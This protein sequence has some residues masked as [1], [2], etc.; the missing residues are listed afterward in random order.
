MEKVCSK[1]LLSG[2]GTEKKKFKWEGRQV[3]TN[4]IK[5][6]FYQSILSYR[7]FSNKRPLS[8]KHPTP[9]NAQYNPKNI[10]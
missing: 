2:L 6:F 3:N 10:L 5:S 1:F 7:I 9:I 8:F 4:Y